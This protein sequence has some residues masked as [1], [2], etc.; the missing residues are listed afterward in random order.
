MAQVLTFDRRGFSAYRAHR[1]KA[2]R[3]I[4]GA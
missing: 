2:V 4:P 3:V 1:G